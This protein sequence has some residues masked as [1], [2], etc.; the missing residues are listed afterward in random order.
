MATRKKPSSS[1]SAWASKPSCHA[2]DGAAPPTRPHHENTTAGG[3]PRSCR[4]LA[5]PRSGYIYRLSGN[6]ADGPRGRIYQ[7][8]QLLENEAPAAGNLHR[9]LDHCLSCRACESVCP[10]K[11]EYG[12]LAEIGRDEAERRIKRPLWQKL[13]RG[14]LRRLITAP[15]LFTPL[16]RIGQHSRPLLPDALKNKILPESARYFCDV[17]S[18]LNQAGA[19]GIILA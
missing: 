18:R 10:A 11:V 5:R 12:K 9:Y 8:K 3:A 17:I 13:Q 4:Y 15:Q 7:I 2:T 16:Y 1:A 6:E 19:A 14:I